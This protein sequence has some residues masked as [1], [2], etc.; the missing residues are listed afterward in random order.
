MYTSQNRATILARFGPS[1]CPSARPFVF[2]ALLVTARL[3]SHAPAA[4]QA[5]YSGP[6]LAACRLCLP[7]AT[8]RPSKPR[9]WSHIA[10]I[11]LL[12][13]ECNAWHHR[14]TLAAARLAHSEMFFCWNTR[15]CNLMMSVGSERV[16]HGAFTVQLYYELTDVMAGLQKPAIDS[17]P[18]SGRRH[19][20][21]AHSRG[22]GVFTGSTSVN[23]RP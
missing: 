18:I 4:A 10:T 7:R 2:P 16:S 20:K 8:V 14:H 19:L 15:T 17:R 12:Y 22:H 9:P 1:A 13:I 3:V 21:S 23:W 6:Q 11:L 5:V